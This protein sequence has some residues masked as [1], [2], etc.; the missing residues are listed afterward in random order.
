MTQAL[1]SA[2]ESIGDYRVR[3]EIL[4]QDKIVLLLQ[5]KHKREVYRN[6]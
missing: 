4:D 6:D 2:I 5:C 1:S 3:Y